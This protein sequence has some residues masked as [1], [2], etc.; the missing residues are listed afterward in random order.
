MI[1]DLTTLD[2]DHKIGI[3]KIILRGKLSKINITNPHILINSRQCNSI[4]KLNNKLDEKEFLNDKFYYDH[5]LYKSSE[6]YL[7][8]LM[9]GDAIFGEKKD[10]NFNGLCFIFMLIV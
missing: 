7:D 5:F 1:Y 3:T 4:G 6:E 10:I 9:R 8:K 2:F